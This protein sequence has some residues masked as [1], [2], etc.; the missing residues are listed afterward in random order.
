MTSL[1]RYSYFAGTRDSPN[2][3]SAT[4]IHGD[5][6]PSRSSHDWEAERHN[7]NSIKFWQKP[8][9][10]QYFHKGLLWRAQEIHEVASYELFVDLLFVGIIGISGDNAAES[11]NGEGLLQ[12]AITFILGWKVWSDIT[13]FVSWF[14][15]DDIVR[16]LCVLFNLV[17]LLGYTTNILDSFADTYSSLIG[18]YLAARLFAALSFTWMAYLIP[19]VRGT[20]ILNSIM[21]ILPS[22]LWIGSI[23]VENPGR[24][25]LIWPAIALDLFGTW[26]IWYL[27]KG[28]LRQIPSKIAEYVAKL[29]EFYPATSIEHKIDRTGA[30]VTLVFGYSVL[31]L[32]YQSRAAMGINAFFG[33]AILALIQAFSFNWMYFEVDAFNLDTHAIRRHWLSG[34]PQPST[35]RV[36]TVAWTNS[37]IQPSGGWPCTFPS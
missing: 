15:A 29:Y 25:A 4:S 16:R 23:H 13:L 34:R 36:C 24:Q 21:I 30:F 28:V 37:Q 19:M 11:A 33:K 9:V 18:F 7:G 14:E 10:R 32:L 5:Q 35:K 26:I 12:F 1:Y 27:Q 20:M 3:S 17:C 31:S 22:I 2:H 8:I 6:T